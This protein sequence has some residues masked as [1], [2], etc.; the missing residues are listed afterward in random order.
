MA[1]FY[2]AAAV[3]PDEHGLAP[4][5]LDGRPIRTPARARLL[6][7]PPVA[8]RIAAEW[9]AQGP[10]IL[11]LTMPFTRLANSAI[12]GVA[13]A[14]PQVQDDI[15]AVA[16]NDLLFYRA[17]A[18]EG[19]VRRQDECWDPLVAWAEQRFG[20]RLV[21]A[22][23]V[24]PVRQDARLPPRVKAALPRE[25]LALAG[26]HQLTT[27]TGSAL[28]ALAVAASRLAFADAWT[29]AHVDEDWNIA[30]WGEDAEA[31]ARREARRRDAEA[32]AAVLAVSRKAD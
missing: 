10:H 29:A 5:L 11:P 1:R 13:A 15:V 18:P 24:M 8:A 30:E 4:V 2:E 6:T 21:L 14:V 19:L 12:D 17:D 28:I 7:P 32:A 27:L 20:V 9:N 3:G 23:G 16:G 22:S 26:L 25:P 31:A